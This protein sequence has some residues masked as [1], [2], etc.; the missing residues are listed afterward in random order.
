M[1]GK[2]IVY[3]SDREEALQRMRHALARFRISGIGT[4]LEFLRRV[5]ADPDFA[6]GRVSTMLVERM[7][8]TM[9][10]GSGACRTRG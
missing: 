7:I 1:I 3:G 10:A 4:T 8:G 6:A 9:V 2:L 5:M